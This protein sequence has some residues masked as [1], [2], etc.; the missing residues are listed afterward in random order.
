MKPFNGFSPGKANSVAIHAQFFSEVLPIVDDVAELKVILFCYWALYQKEGQYRY[1]RRSDFGRDEALMRG[2]TVVGRDTAALLDSALEKAVAH[3]VLLVAEV[4][5][6]NQAEHLYFLN[7]TKGQAA[8]RQITAGEWHPGEDQFVEILPERP[9]IFTLYEDNIGPLTPI[10][11]E[12]LK[13]AEL[14]YSY[15]WIV[16]AINVAI[17]N[18]IRRWNYIIKILERWKQEGRA[19]ATDEAADRHRGANGRDYTGGEYADFIDS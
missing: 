17:E 16:D 3:G 7:T 4:E 8:I 13:D 19:H 10:I 18:N 6:D 14:D 5:L 9:N 15:Q 11:A 2:L 12:H 1:L